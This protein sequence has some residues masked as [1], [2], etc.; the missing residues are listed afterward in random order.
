[1]EIAWGGIVIA[2]ASARW[3]NGAS[4]LL[5]G[6]GEGGAA[7][8]GWSGVNDDLVAVADGVYAIGSGDEDG[9]SM[10]HRPAESDGIT[11]TVGVGDG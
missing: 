3:E 7:R 10:G 4:A 5:D 1:M 8:N 11:E 2:A 9:V 6:N